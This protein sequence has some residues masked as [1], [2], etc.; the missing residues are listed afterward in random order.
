MHTLLLSL[1]SCIRDYWGVNIW[2][3]GA[4][5]HRSNQ[6]IVHRSS[7]KNHFSVPKWSKTMDVVVSEKL[8]FGEDHSE[9]ATVAWD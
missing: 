7:E 6:L 9:G 1:R 2:C 3:V 5:H 4:S 8:T